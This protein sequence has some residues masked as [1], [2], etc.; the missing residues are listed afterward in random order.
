MRLYHQ[1]IST[2]EKKGFIC[3]F[4]REA[5]AGRPWPGKG[6]PFSWVIGEA[7][8]SRVDLSRQDIAPGCLSVHGL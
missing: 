8:V 4:T 7:L 6:P 3:D 1:V 2:I 5:R